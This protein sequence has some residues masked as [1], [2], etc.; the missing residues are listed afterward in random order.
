MQFLRSVFPQ[1]VYKLSKYKY[2]YMGNMCVYLL[3]ENNHK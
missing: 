1:Y 3:N 2:V